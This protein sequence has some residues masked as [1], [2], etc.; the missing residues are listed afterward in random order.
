MDKIMKLKNQSINH[1]ITLKEISNRIKNS[2][3]FGLLLVP[4]KSRPPKNYKI[5]MRHVKIYT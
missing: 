5:H 3:T 4:L 2:H 1:S